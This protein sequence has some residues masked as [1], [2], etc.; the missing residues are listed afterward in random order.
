MSWNYE[1]EEQSFALLPEGNYRIRIKS[2]EKAVSK[3]GN[4]MLALQ[5]EVSGSNKILYHYIVFM[6]HNPQLTNKLLTAFF[7]AF[8]DI[9]EGDFNL[10]NWI[11]KV[12]ACHI[13]HEEDN[14]YGE[15]ERISYFIKADKQDSLPAW[16]E[17]SGS[18]TGAGAGSAPVVTVPIEEEVPF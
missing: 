5:F 10:A 17:P 1:R 7:D 6:E 11:G 9:T 3:S 14:G 4:D 18:S 8:K 13:K 15:K 12:G 16:V 2:A